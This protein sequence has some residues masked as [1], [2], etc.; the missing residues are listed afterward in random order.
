M[1]QPPLGEDDETRTKKQKEAL[2]M[3]FQGFTPRKIRAK[4]WDNKEKKEKDKEDEESDND[5]EFCSIVSCP[6][7]CRR[8]TD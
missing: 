5:G 4:V 1:L 8:Y 2:E 3:A 6:W 7:I